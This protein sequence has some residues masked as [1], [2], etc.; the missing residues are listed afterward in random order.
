MNLLGIN[1]LIAWHEAG[2]TQIPWGERAR[3]CYA[4]KLRKSS[5]KLVENS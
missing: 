5:K 3:K 4:E 2:N 1:E